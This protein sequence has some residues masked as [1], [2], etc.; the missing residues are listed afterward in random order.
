MPRRLT[1]DGRC[2]AFV[3][4]SS[5]TE[6]W[7]IGLYLCFQKESNYWRG[8]SAAKFLEPWLMGRDAP[9]LHAKHYSSSPQTAPALGK[10]SLRGSVKTLLNQTRDGL[11]EHVGA[12]LADNIHRLP[13]ALPTLDFALLRVDEVNRPP[14][15]S[16]GSAR[17]FDATYRGT[18]VALKLL[19]EFKKKKTNKQTKPPATFTFA[20]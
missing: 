3:F 5:A 20:I 4:F 13:E 1:A 15:G 11:E 14:I 9:T 8:L 19:C 16:G 10:S 18:P 7:P 12:L 6:A 17:V 2:P